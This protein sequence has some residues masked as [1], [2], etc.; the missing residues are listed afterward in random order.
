MTMNIPFLF[1]LAECEQNR[2]LKR[3]L[4]VATLLTVFTIVLTGSRG[5]FLAMATVFAA[6]VLKSRYKAVGIGAG[7]LGLVLFVVLIPQDY[8]DRLMS[9]TTAIEKDGSAQG[10]I[11][12][13]GVAVRMIKDKPFF[14]VGFQNFVWAYPYYGKKEL[15]K[16]GFALVA[17][18]SYLQIWAESGTFA[19]GFFVGIIFST[20]FLMRRLQRVNR[21]RDGPQWIES[22]AKAIE[23]TLYGFLMGAMFLNRAHFDFLYQ[24]CAVGSAL[25]PIAL[26]EIERHNRP[27][28]RRGV[29]KL[30]VHRKDPFLAGSST[31]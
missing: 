9:I 29:A 13:W 19:F 11:R 31:P 10:R 5:G 2:N 24:A 7:F 22:Y 17:H 20:I 12:A 14:G 18:N 25:Y 4:L 6:I 1:Y 15:K 21:V 26:L 23:V 30:R 16:Q 3:F 27:R 28:G 8:R